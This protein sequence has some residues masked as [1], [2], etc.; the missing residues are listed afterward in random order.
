MTS[1][2]EASDEAV[3]AKARGRLKSA[4]TSSSQPG[5]FP[6][7][8]DH[9]VSTDSLEP[10]VLARSGELVA[11]PEEQ[12]M[13]AVPNPMRSAAQQNRDTSRN[14]KKKRTSIPATVKPGV[15]SVRQASDSG[16]TGRGLRSKGSKL[17]NTKSRSAATTTANVAS[18]EFENS[19]REYVAE[20]RR[21]TGRGLRRSKETPQNVGSLTAKTKVTGKK[22]TSSDHLNEEI[23]SLFHD[24]LV[25]PDNEPLHDENEMVGADEDISNSDSDNAQ[26]EDATEEDILRS[27]SKRRT[28]HRDSISSANGEFKHRRAL[29]LRKLSKDPGLTVQE[30]DVLV[31]HIGESGVDHSKNYLH[32]FLLASNC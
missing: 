6:F 2:K 13:P 18:G 10:A 3:K 20:R 31:Q 7:Q 28:S 21:Q 9:H 24:E 29:P 26:F 1:K 14:S 12:K 5:S 30:H 19:S 25:S 16:N 23:V 27:A 11:L 22:D 4:A 17:R 32:S 15:V 8:H